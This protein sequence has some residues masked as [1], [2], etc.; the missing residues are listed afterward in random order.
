MSFNSST[1]ARSG[2][3]KR[4]SAWVL[5]LI[6]VGL[7]AACGGGKPDPQAAAQAVAAES[8]AALTGVASQARKRIQAVIVGEPRM[9]TA[10]ELFTWAQA[11]YP[12]YF[13][14]NPPTQTFAPYTYRHY[15]NDNYLAVANGD[16]WILGPLA[17]S[18]TTPVRVGAVLDFAC[19]VKPQACGNT[20]VL[21]ANI[22]GQDREFIVYVPWQSIGMANLPAVFML[23]GTSGD[24]QQFYLHS[25]WKEQ[26]DLTGLVAVFPTA[27]WHCFYQDDNKDGSFDL[28]AERHVVTKW[29]AGKLGDPSERPLCTDAQKA[30][31]SADKRALVDHPLADDMGL[32]SHMVSV[33]TNQFGVDRRRVYASGFSNGAEMSGRL[34]AEMSTTFAAVA[35][36]SSAVSVNTVAARP[37]SLIWTVGE[38]DPEQSLAMGYTNGVIPLTADLALNPH[39]IAAVQFPFTRMLQLAFTHTHSQLTA[40]TK[41]IS[42]FSYTIS[43]IGAANSFNGY[44]IQGLGHEYPNGDNHPVKMAEALWGFF[45]TQTLP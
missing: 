24:G 18:N 19:P 29:A 26:A 31:L 35:C 20:H 2:W 6:A 44:V 40:Y 16:V 17:G 45:Q 25:G 4:A 30:G 3:L 8:A 42:H 34:A 43:Q 9:P 37:L 11:K 38:L 27:L 13:P 14:G 21:T 22:S 15:S 39:F 36:S 1:P 41:L 33:L 10:D 12:Q 7:V 32:F 23:H 5:P 28:I